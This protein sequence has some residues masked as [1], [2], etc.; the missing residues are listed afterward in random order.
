MRPSL[1][2][3]SSIKSSTKA[4]SRRNRRDR[5]LL[6]MIVFKCVEVFRKKAPLQPSIGEQYPPGDYP[7][8]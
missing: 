5:H 8:D 3:S 2:A 7:T 4:F 6:G 1:H